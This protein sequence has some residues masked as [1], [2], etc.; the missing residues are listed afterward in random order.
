[1]KL[2]GVNE[3]EIVKKKL[4]DKLKERLKFSEEENQIEQLEQNI[5]QQQQQIDY[6][7]RQNEDI[8]ERMSLRERILNM[9]I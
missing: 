3:Q 8:E 5:E 4:L 2:L 7:E 6:L 1:M 9:L